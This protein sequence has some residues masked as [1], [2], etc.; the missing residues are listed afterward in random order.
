MA[1]L[2]N[3]GASSLGDPAGYHDGYVSLGFRVPLFTGDRDIFFYNCDDD[4]CDNGKARPQ[5]I[6]MP[7]QSYCDDSEACI[8]KV[9]G[10]ELFHHVQ[11]AHLWA[12]GTESSTCSGSLDK[13]ACE[14]QARAM[15]D[16]IYTDL[17][18]NNPASCASFD[19]EVDDY[20]QDP[21]Q[22]LWSS[23][24]EAALWW[25]YL[26]EQHGF[27]TQEPILGVDFVEAF[28]DLV[29][30]LG[31]AT[32]TYAL[33][34]ILVEVYGGDLVKDFR[35]FLLA[36][37]I[38]DLD[39]TG[40]SQAFVDRYTY[41][42]DGAA[43]WTEVP[44]AGSVVTP[45][46][47][48][49]VV[50]ISYPLWGASYTEVDTTPCGAINALRVGFTPL[51][52]PNPWSG[53]LPPLVINGVIVLQGS[54]P[55]KPAALYYKTTSSAWVL[56]LI[57]GLD[58]YDRLI[59]VTSSL[60]PA[61]ASGLLTVVC[62]TSPLDIVRFDDNPDGLWFGPSGANGVHAI[63]VS[64]RDQGAGA[65]RGLVGVDP[66]L[67][68]V[69][70]GGQHA[71]VVAVVPRG[72]GYR[73]L[74]EPPLL[75]NGLYDL[76]VGYQGISQTWTDGARIGPRA[77][78]HYLLADTSSS[79][80]LPTADSRLDALRAAG[81]AWVAHLPDGGGLGVVSYAGDDTE[82]NVDAVVEVP[83]AANDAGL[84][85]VAS[86]ELATLA[87]GPG[88]FTSIGDALDLAAQQAVALGAF[89]DVHEVVLVS[90]GAENEGDFWSDVEADVLAAGLV[91]HTVALGGWSD[92]GLLAE[93]ARRTGGVYR[94]VDVPA[95]GASSVELADALAAVADRAAR[96]TR[97]VERDV[98]LPAGSGGTRTSGPSEIVS[99]DL[100]GDAPVVSVLWENPRD[101]LELELREP[102]DTPV[103]D[104]V[105]GARVELG[106]TFIVFHL[107]AAETGAYQLEIEGSSGASARVLASSVQSIR[108]E[109]GFFADRADGTA[110]ATELRVGDA[111][112]LQATV[113]D[114]IVPVTGAALEVAIT[115]PDGTVEV[116]PLLDDGNGADRLAGDGLYG[117]RY[118][119]ATAGS[120][121]GIPDDSSAPEQ[122]G[123]YNVVLI[124][125]VDPNSIWYQDDD[126]HV[127]PDLAADVDGDALPPGY[128]ARHPC[129]DPA[130][131]DELGDPDGD[132][133]SSLVELQR[134]LDPCNPDSDGSG[135]NDGSEVR[136][137]GDPLD[138]DDDA[139]RRPAVLSLERSRSEHED[140]PPFPPFANVLRLNAYPEHT[141]LE[142]WRATG[143]T[144]LQLVDTVDT[145]TS[146]GFWVDPGLTP[147]ETYT[148]QVV[149]LDA[150]GNESAPS[151]RV[152]AEAKADPEPPIASLVLARGAPR[153]DDEELV[154]RVGLHFD[155]PA[156][157][158]YRAWTSVVRV[159]TA[160]QP[161][162]EDIGI[163]IGPA[164]APR[165]VR[166]SVQ[167]RDA[168][169]NESP[170]VSASIDQHPPG[171][172]GS[173]AGTLQTVSS[174]SL[175]P[176]SP[177]LSGLAPVSAFVEIAGS[178]TEPG[179]Q[180]APDGGFLLDELLPGSY[181][182]EI[183]GFG[184]APVQLK[185]VAVAAGQSTD[186][187]PQSLSCPIEQTVADLVVP[188]P[189]TFRAQ[190]QVTLGGNL[191]LGGAGTVAV[192]ASQRISIVGPA[193]FQGVVR[194]SI[195]PDPCVLP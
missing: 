17:D 181:D 140:Q 118:D 101:V 102:D 125:T 168:A 121:T 139:L 19:G 188:G 134:G 183:S 115:H 72:D 111:V 80:L 153:T 51:P 97:I 20:L 95:G 194:L 180:S 22:P 177:L 33:T 12:S 186:V 96:R 84:R 56:N 59:V 173:I 192:E 9:L 143:A 144:G 23:S 90:D 166:V 73:L 159:P 184:Y 21:G 163:A 87:S 110:S 25:T 54:T 88:R 195:V 11:Y 75:A 99:L 141:A 172:L 167:L 32:G 42:D 27:E 52:V 190:E 106:D 41:R 161:Y 14:G 74:V 123:S 136:R 18:L 182:L 117:A 50:P 44:F 92:Q 65:G 150:D 91:V 35:A 45:A 46:S 28:W 164:S 129:L 47:G 5:W 83:L 156:R 70:I 43:V 162:V 107:P 24:Y 149:A 148:Y 130:I 1:A 142:V 16:K 128:E 171:S 145:K 94:Y 158:E 127:L 67:F 40:L 86:A 39:V 93:I 58:P 71:R 85:A 116:L 82:P 76:E 152:S 98:V 157:T 185:G 114:G 62:D 69:E 15:Q 66:S 179:T 78:N 38:K 191:N 189:Q 2:D 175:G 112:D 174:A 36:N 178:S 6:R 81:P 29:E 48:A 31:P 34:D 79:M 10:H 193:T 154:A 8:R 49:T 160:W 68:E 165:T 176:Q 89:G 119:R 60:F 26:M 100:R 4:E 109:L 103:V 64:I 169:G 137:G 30:L 37:A 13:T 113:L 124:M 126:F 77:T 120:P 187:G 132:D 3:A 147:G 61:P 104:G 7:S 55:G 105:G 131:D 63:D 133:L 108:I 135:E 146:T 155:E 57:Q 170:V 122:R 151:A 138:P 53:F